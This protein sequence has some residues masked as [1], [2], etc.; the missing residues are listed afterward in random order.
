MLILFSAI[1]LLIA[2][3]VGATLR[4]VLAGLPSSNQDLSWW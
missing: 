4:E 1:A 3:R 2:I